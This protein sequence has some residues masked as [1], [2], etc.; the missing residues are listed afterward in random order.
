MRAAQ[1]D[2]DLA[3]AVHVE[4][5]VAQL[6]LAVA[7]QLDGGLE[8][9]VGELLAAERE[10][11][12]LGDEV[13][14]QAEVGGEAVLVLGQARAVV[15]QEGDGAARAARQA[16]VRGEPRGDAG[17]DVQ[18]LLDR[19]VVREVGADLE[20]AAELGV[21]LLQLD[22]EV[23]VGDQHDLDVERGRLDAQQRRT[24]AVLVGLDRARE[25]AG[26]EVL[27]DPLALDQGLG[28]ED[29]KAAVGA[30][31]VAREDRA[32]LGVATLAGAGD[33]APEQARE[34]D[35]LGVHDR[36][37]LPLA[38]GDQQGGDHQAGWQR[39]GGQRQ[40]VALLEVVDLADVAV[41]VGDVLPQLRGREDRGDR[42]EAGLDVAAQRRPLPLQQ[43]GVA[44]GLDERELTLGLL[45]VR[46]QG[47]DRVEV[48]AADA[49]GALVVGD[50]RLFR[51]VG[52][53]GGVLGDVVG[54]LPLAGGLVDRVLL[55]LERDEVEA[56]VVGDQAHAVG[57]GD[58]AEGVVELA[59]GGALLAV[60]LELQAA[61][62]AA[63]E[64]LVDRGLEAGVQLSHGPH[65]AR[66][67]PRGQERRDRF[68]RP[69]RVG[70]EDQISR[71]R[72][73]DRL[74]A[75]QGDRREGAAGAALSD[76]GD[77]EARGA[78]GEASTQGLDG[79]PLWG[80]ARAQLALGGGLS[81]RGLRDVLGAYLGGAAG[82]VERESCCH[83]VSQRRRA[84]HRRRRCHRSQ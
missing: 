58:L 28:V 30:V 39:R 64:D 48:L 20:E 57:G 21:E 14:E 4:Q 71:R 68:E 7:H 38:V 31:D 72:A 16:A 24:L 61:A 79:A 35:V 51:V 56:V 25:Q 60:D 2:P 12:G 15:H 36:R 8:V 62:H 74:G 75:G 78:L 1:L 82:R 49:A 63:L 52:R 44:L 27:V 10:R 84:E 6:T 76:H 29:E 47:L 32:G 59:L 83:G 50:L 41:Q 9:L 53:R 18:A 5:A 66:A 17:V 54:G 3:V 80:D 22:D 37:G 45:D 46:A 42:G 43:V 81:E 26:L 34:R 33:D 65:E 69:A 11:G 55:V 73:A 40:V 23:G 67:C 13:A 19:H 77:V 70:Q